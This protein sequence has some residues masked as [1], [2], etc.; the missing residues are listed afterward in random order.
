MD[1]HVYVSCPHHGLDPLPNDGRWQIVSVHPLTIT[2]S[3]H[4][5]DCGCHG[6]ITDGK[7]RVTS[8]SEWEVVSPEG[9]VQAAYPSKA[10]ADVT[11]DRMPPGH[12]IRNL[13]GGTR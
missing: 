9:V 6:Y 4:W 8:M 7:W 12:Y 10:S 2:P 5:T 1:D 3:V 11:C 13:A